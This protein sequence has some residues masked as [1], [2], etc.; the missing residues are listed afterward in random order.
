MNQSE[1]AELINKIEMQCI[2]DKLK[3]ENNLIEQ[4][5]KNDEINMIMHK[6]INLINAP[7]YALINDIKLSV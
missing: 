7:L 4:Q 3:H 6:S 5:M 1:R 2:N